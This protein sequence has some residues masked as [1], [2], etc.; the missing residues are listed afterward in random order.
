MK[1]R[2]HT[3]GFTLIEAILYI[4]VASSMLYAVVLL[5][6]V[7]VS[8]E[9]G[10][11]AHA[12]VTNSSGHTLRMITDAIRR[13]SSVITPEHHAIDGTLV[14]EMA[15]AGVS[16]TTFSLVDGIVVMQEGAGP[17]IPLSAPEVVIDSLQ[18][19]NLSVTEVSDSIH[20][21]FVATHP[22]MSGRSEVDFSETFYGS[23]TTK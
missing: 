3:R 8:N 1:N 21:E 19:E 11:T 7:V 17:V 13:S 23:A 4:A 15:D 12:S 22:N 9:A 10:N 5:Y 16:P 18:F 14:L 2:T 6:N 20:I